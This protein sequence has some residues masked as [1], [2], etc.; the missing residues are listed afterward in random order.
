MAPALAPLL[1]ALA[2]IPAGA[3]V[4]A[5]GERVELIALEG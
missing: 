3:G 4:A 2:L 1:G 5:D